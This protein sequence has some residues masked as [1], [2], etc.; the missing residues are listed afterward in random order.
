MEEKRITIRFN[1]VDC[2]SLMVGFLSN[3]EKRNEISEI[4]GKW[5]DYKTVFVLF[6]VFI[7]SKKIFC[8]NVHPAVVYLHHRRQSGTEK[9][10]KQRIRFL[11]Q[12]L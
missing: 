12:I 9:T 1:D 10:A 2:C 4:Y 11:L 8:S 6:M 7:H 3:P 5:V